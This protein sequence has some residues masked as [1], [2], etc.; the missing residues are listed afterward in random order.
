MDEALLDAATA[1]LTR[2]GFEGLSL[3]RVA[4]EVGRS[5]VT[6]WRQGVTKETL[7]AGLLDRLTDDFQQTFWPIIN[8]RGSG[9]ERLAADLAALF[10]VADRHL[11]L[12]AVSDEVFH[13]A[14]EERGYATPA[15]GFLGPFIAALRLGS[16]D[17]SL[18]FDG[19]ADDVADVL[20]NSA[21]WGYVHLR[22]RHAWAAKRARKRLGDLLLEGVRSPV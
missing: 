12:L 16:S 15:D 2:D 13:W 17:G 8:G 14:A 6:L 3:E 9:R 7:V 1:I 21:C 22:H 10:Q 20:F 4:E 18:S 5:R 19:P 11:D